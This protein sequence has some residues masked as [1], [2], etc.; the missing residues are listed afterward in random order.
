MAPPVEDLGLKEVA[1]VDIDNHLRIGDQG[2]FEDG[3]L[4]LLIG[5]HLDGGIGDDRLAHDRS[6]LRQ[7]HGHVGVDL[8]AVGF[9]DAEVVISVSQLVGEGEDPVEVLFIIEQDAGFLDTGDGHAESACAFAVLGA[10]IDPVLL[11]GSV[12]EIGQVLGELAEVL[13]DEFL[14]FSIGEFAADLAEG[15]EQV[16]PGEGFLA[17]FFG[18]GLEVFAEGGEGALHRIQHG[19]EGF[20]VN[21]GLVQGGV[22]GVFPAAAGEEHILLTLD[23]VQGSG[24]GNFDG[25]PGGQ[26]RLRSRGGAWLRLHGCAG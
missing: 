4:L 21:A 5:S 19:F 17:Q 7:G 23:T 13:E 1:G 6:G 25:L 14:G 11:E 22:D 15:G 10:D 26:V 9:V 3:K 2:G 20:P 12:G 8:G 24:Q 16:P 18:F